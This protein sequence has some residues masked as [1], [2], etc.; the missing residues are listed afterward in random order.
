MYLAAKLADQLWSTD[1]STI[2]CVAG[3]GV[4][5]GPV[6]TLQSVAS[7][8]S[9]GASPRDLPAAAAGARMLPAHVPVVITRFYAKCVLQKSCS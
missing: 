1:E 2:N 6:A 7:G 4:R 3:A 8:S 5:A 9:G